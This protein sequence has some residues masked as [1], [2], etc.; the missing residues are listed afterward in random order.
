M[1]RAAKVDEQ[2]TLWRRAVG[3]FRDQRSFVGRDGHVYLYGEDKRQRRREVFARDGGRCVRCGVMVG[4]EWGEMDHEQGGLVGRCD[5][6][7]NLQVM[8]AECHRTGKNRKH[9]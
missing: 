4:K 8:C 5:C 2:A 7:H 1:P 6:L 3:H 9:A